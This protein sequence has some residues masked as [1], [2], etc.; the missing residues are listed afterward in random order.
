M[1][2]EYNHHIQKALIELDYVIEDME[3]NKKINKEY[4]HVVYARKSLLESNPD[5]A[6]K[7]F[8]ERE[9]WK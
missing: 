6:D 5:V 1:M 9:K 7:Y 4:Q 3:Y 8:L 2:S